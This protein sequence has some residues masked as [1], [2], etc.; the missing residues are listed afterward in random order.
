MKTLLLLAVVAC[1]CSSPSIIAGRSDAREAARVRART[2][3]ISE[4]IGKPV[5][6]RNCAVEAFSGDVPEGRL[7]VEVTLT[8]EGRASDASIVGDTM[9]SGKLNEC[10][11]ERIRTLSFPP[12]PHDG[13]SFTSALVFKGA[14]AKPDVVTRPR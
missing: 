1:G 7:V 6:F 11:L 9:R 2:A 4:V 13:E 14:P 10:V 12:A 8:R 3:R 5:G